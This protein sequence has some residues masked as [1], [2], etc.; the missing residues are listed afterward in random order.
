MEL[1]QFAD[2]WQKKNSEGSVRLPF[3]ISYCTREIDIKVFA[4]NLE[5]FF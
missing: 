4:L 3:N 5:Y 2:K 1:E